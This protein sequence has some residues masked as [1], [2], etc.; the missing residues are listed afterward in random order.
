MVC[1]EAGSSVELCC[2]KLLPLQYFC[3]L[4]IF[5][6]QYCYVPHMYTHYMKQPETGKE[7]IP[8]SERCLRTASFQSSSSWLLGGAGAGAFWAQGSGSCLEGGALGLGVRPFLSGNE[9]AVAI[10]GLKAA[11]SLEER[12]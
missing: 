5:C 6:T 4:G 2:F 8:I 1:L 9:Q 11:R 7:V 10:A 12:H 3:Q